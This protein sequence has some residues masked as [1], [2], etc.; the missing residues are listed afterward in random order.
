MGKNG[1][2]GMIL[3]RRYEFGITSVRAFGRANGK[4][5]GAQV[6]WPL[7]RSR[8]TECGR[9]LRHRAFAAGGANPV[10][11][12]AVLAPAAIA[13]QSCC[14][15]AP[16]EESECA[17]QE[18]EEEDGHCIDTAHSAAHIKAARFT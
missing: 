6:S 8:G 1:R 9:V 11:R 17:E 5:T 4:L 18:G 2:F 13:G 16:V 14:A 7:A 3:A 15:A 10:T 12:R